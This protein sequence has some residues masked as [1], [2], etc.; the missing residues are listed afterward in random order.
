[1]SAVQSSARGLRGG[2]R[3]R[4]LDE[5]HVSKGVILSCA[6][7]FGLPSLHMK[8]DDLAKMTRRENEFTAAQVV[9]YPDRLVGFLSVEI[10]LLI[11]VSMRSAIGAEATS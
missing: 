2:R 4:A 10:R 8:P 7:L 5:A 11:P 3:A 1:M 6:Y 9:Q